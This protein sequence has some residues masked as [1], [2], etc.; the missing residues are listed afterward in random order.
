MHPS[1]K[2]CPE[3]RH[4][5]VT[6]EYYSECPKCCDSDPDAGFL[7]Q[8]AVLECSCGLAYSEDDMEAA[9]DCFRWYN[10]FWADLSWWERIKA[11]WEMKGF[12]KDRAPCGFK[13]KWASK[14]QWNYG[15]ECE[16]WEEYYQCSCGE[17]LEYANG[18]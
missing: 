4:Q 7:M 12:P 15:C 2:V 3:C 8:E 1:L 14:P 13:F 18:T 16:D 10:D 5:E 6:D 11:V 17:V 9:L